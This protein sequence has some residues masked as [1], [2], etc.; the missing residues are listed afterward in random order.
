M[1]I[2]MLEMNKIIIFL[3]CSY[4]ILLLIYIY[5]KIRKIKTI[6]FLSLLVFALL[7]LGIANNQFTSNVF[8]TK[9]IKPDDYNKV[10]RIYKTTD[11]LLTIET[12]N[13]TIIIN[14][15]WRILPHSKKTFNVKYLPESDNYLLTLD[16]LSIQISNNE[17]KNLLKVKN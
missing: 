15:N 17:Y 9:E 11:F 2:Y 7:P 8:F 14:K 3:I 5:V 6:S 10:I 1:N 4:F 13:E 12:K 16:S